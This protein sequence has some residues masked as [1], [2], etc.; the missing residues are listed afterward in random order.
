M[1]Q[2]RWEGGGG[3]AGARRGGPRHR[4]HP[5]QCPRPQ[6]RHRC[7]VLRPHPRLLDDT[8]FQGLLAEEDDQTITLKIEN[9]VLK[10]IKK[11]DLNGPIIV[12][13]KSLMPEGLG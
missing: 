7:A 5:G 11:A 2:V 4:V 3:W 9:A 10:K 6:S 1:P 13:E 8:V 12:S